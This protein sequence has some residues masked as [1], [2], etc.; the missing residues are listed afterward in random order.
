LAE[1][2]IL[3][4]SLSYTD[5]PQDALEEARQAA[6]RSIQIDP[7]CAEAH[8]ALAL[9]FSRADWNWK[10]AEAEFLRAIELNQGYAGAHHQ[11]AMHL[12]RLSRLEE[13]RREITL[14]H[15]LDPL[16][17]IISTAVGRILHFSRRYDEAIEQCRRTLTLDANFAPGYFDL[18]V[19]CVAATRW[20][21]AREALDNLDALER[22][23]LRRSILATIYYG[24]TGQIDKARAE[25]RRLEQACGD[26]EI[27]RGAL[28][29]ADLGI[30]DLDR[31]L[32]DLEKAVEARE[33][34]V[35][36]MQCEPV[37]DPI[38]EHPR[39]KALLEKVGLA[40]HG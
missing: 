15:A 24:R 9:V 22:S 8:V 17:L 29:I 7:D 33:G 38:R 23:D 10:A 35:V 34:T 30:G 20:E 19:S 2:N 1:T 27:T 37:Y 5:R 18:V 26:R 21:E 13:A 31:A 14:A 25:R 6:K 28:A 16:S 4:A 12:A 32:D 3:I 40:K 36:Y 39:F 11:Y